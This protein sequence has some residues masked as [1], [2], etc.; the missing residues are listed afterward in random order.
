MQRFGGAYR[1]NPAGGEKKFTWEAKEP[2][3][4]FQAFIRNERRYSS[5]LKT[6]PT[7]AEELFAL[8][9]ADAKKR[10]NFMQ[11]LGELM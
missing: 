7:E 9:E 4:N 5:L 3:G 2:T 1:F 6:A 10:W 8:A 11:K